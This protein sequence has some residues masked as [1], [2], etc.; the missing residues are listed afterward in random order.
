VSILRGDGSGGFDLAGTL[1]AGPAPVSIAV[2]DVNGDSVPDL[3]IANAAVPGTV[4]LLLGNGAGGFASGATSVVAA[5]PVSV[6]MADFNADG[7]ADLASANYVGDSVS[8]LLGL[9]DGSFAA[10]ASFDAHLYPTAMA[11]S[12]VNGDGVPDLVLSNLQRATVSVLVGLGDGS[13][14]DAGSFGAGEA[15]AALAVADFNGDGKPDVATANGGAGSVSI[16]LNQSPAAGGTWTDLGWGL[17]GAAGVPLLSGG[18]PQLAGQS[19]WIALAGA[20]PG[21]PALL[22]VSLSA[23]PTPFKGGTLVPLPALAALPLVTSDAGALTLSLAWPAGL[24]SAFAIHFQ[25]G[26]ADPAAAQGVAL[27]NALR[28]KTP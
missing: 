2:G 11:A 18:G 21:S 13:F 6:V 8:V 7:K 20:K 28:S 25:Y 16:L 19:V 9:G 10:P 27:S 14:Q 15:P 4:R 5:V 17:A 22:L 3:A 26:I 12:D 1:P 23:A 24:P